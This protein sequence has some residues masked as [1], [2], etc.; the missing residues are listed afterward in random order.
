MP[1]RP[2]ESCLSLLLLAA[3]GGAG[4]AWELDDT[5]NRQRLSRALCL[6]LH[7]SRLGSEVCLRQL[8]AAPR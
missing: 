1:D 2:L 6:E 5:I 7:L 8:L 3:A 4:A